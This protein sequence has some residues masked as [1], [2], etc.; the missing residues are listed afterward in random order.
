MWR[1]TR[2]RWLRPYDYAANALRAAV[3]RRSHAAGS[4]LAPGVRGL[5][6]F[7]RGAASAWRKR[8]VARPVIYTLVGCTA[9]ERCVIERTGDRFPHPRGRHLRGQRLGAVPGRVGKGVSARAGF[10]CVRSPT[11]RASAGRGAKRWRVGLAPCR[12]ANLTGC[13]EPVLNPYTRLAVAMSPARGILRAAGYDTTGA[14]LPQRV[15][16]ICEIEFQ[17]RA[18]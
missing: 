7:R 12:P 11:R 10:W 1:R 15:T 5:R 3:G 16:Q 18:A 17:P 14:T 13:A 4:A 8:R 6:R 2:H 9:N